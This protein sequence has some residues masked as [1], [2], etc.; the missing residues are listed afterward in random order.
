MPQPIRRCLRELR[1]GYSNRIAVDAIGPA[2]KSA[3]VIVGTLITSK[4]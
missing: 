2:E 4:L 3:P 1:Y